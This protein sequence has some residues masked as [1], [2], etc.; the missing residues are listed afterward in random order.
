[1]RFDL[2]RSF[3]ERQKPGGVYVQHGCD[4]EKEIQGDG[5][6]NIRRFDR[7]HVLAA[8]AHPLGQLLLGQSGVLAVLGDV[9][10]QFDEFLRVVKFRVA[11]LRHGPH[12]C[13]LF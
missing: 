10:A 11:R 2:R 13:P 1:M 3:P 6:A 8:D 9:V 12:L 7:A 5:A 4:I